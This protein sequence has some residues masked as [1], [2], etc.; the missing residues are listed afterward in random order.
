M[1]DVELVVWMMLKMKVV[2]NDGEEKGG[3]MKGEVHGDAWGL[4]VGKGFVWVGR[5]GVDVVEGFRG[6]WVGMLCGEGLMAVEFWD[7]ECK[8][9][10]FWNEIFWGDKG[11]L[12]WI[13]RERGWG[14]GK[15]Y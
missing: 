6:E 12:F 10:W 7:E 9:V 1:F 2:K 8:G 15:A 3:L 5:N 11:L 13:K 4:G 14:G